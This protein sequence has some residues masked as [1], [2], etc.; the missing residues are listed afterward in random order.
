MWWFGWHSW[1]SRGF[2]CD[3][4]FIVC[5]N[6]FHLFKNV[7]HI[8]QSVRFSKFYKNPLPNLCMECQNTFQWTKIPMG[9]FQVCDVLNIL[10]ELDKPHVEHFEGFIPLLREGGELQFFFKTLNR[11]FQ[12]KNSKEFPHW[13]NKSWRIDGGRN[14]CNNNNELLRKKVYWSGY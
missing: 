7:V 8:Q 11:K 4:G 6:Q 14:V 5:M 2:E 13:I 3:G 12:L 1:W 9:S 10:F